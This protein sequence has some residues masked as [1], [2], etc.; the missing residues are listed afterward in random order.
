MEE[1]VG[2]VAIS[3]M[4]AAVGGLFIW[5]S[6]VLG[7]KHPNPTKS[8]PFECG[9]KPFTLPENRLP[10]KFYL[11]AMLFIIF[12]VELIFLFPW[13]VM[14]R[15]LGVFGLIEF[16]PFALVLIVG[17]AYVWKQGALDWQRSDH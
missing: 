5:L 9:Q 1:Y 16:F 10:V 4:A 15:R 14:F 6:S 12:D 2:V 8:E 7:P 3:L 17:L 13:S 11:V